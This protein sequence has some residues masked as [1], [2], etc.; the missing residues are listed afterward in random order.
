[1]FAELDLSALD[2]AGGAKKFREIPRFPSTARDIAL[3]APL[4]L[5]HEK[6]VTTLTGAHE[7]LL[8]S[9]ELFDVFTDPAGAHI[10]AD[11]KSLAYSLTYRA[12]DRTLAADE[13]N[14]AHARLKERLKSTLG[15]TL[16]E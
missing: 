9:I 13:V 4:T 6:I 11:Q 15:V 16:R 12:P 3:L 10:P 7:P 1:L 5:P 2:T 8:E 14:A